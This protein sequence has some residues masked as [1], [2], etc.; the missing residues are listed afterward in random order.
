MP[1]SA[2]AF[3]PLVDVQARNMGEAQADVAIRGGIFET[4]GF[5][6]GAVALYDP[7]TGHYSAEI[8]AAP[9]MLSAPTVLTGADNAL[10]GW[11]ANAGTIAYEWRRVRAG[12]AASAG[13]G[14]HALRRAEAYQGWVAPAPLAAAAG[15]RRLAFDAALAAADSD[16]SRP[17]GESRFRRC[18]ARVQLAGDGGQTDLFYGRQSKFIGWPN[19]YTP[20]ADVFETDDLRTE[21]LVLNHREEL[22]GGDFVAAG[23]YWRRNADHYVFNRDGPAHNAGFGA[24]LP[25]RHTTWVRGAGVE[26][27]LA[28]GAV[29][30][31]FSASF[32]A[33]KLESDT[34]T[35]GRFNTRNHARVSLAPETSWALAGA[36]K[37]SVLAGAV[38]DD[39]NRDAPAVSPVARL[40]LANAAP[41][42]LADEVYV[43]CAA[44]SQVAT[45]TA[46]N[47]HPSAGLFRG[48][49]DL[50]RE[51][52]RA[53]ELGV[54]GARDNW[55]WTAAVFHRAERG[56]V[57]WIYRTSLPNARAA[58]AVD[59]DTTG[60]ELVARYAGRRLDLV[61]GYA[62][63]RKE[64][65]YGNTDADASFYA[66]N[67]PEHRLTA[68]VTVRA[69]RGWE[70]RLD[71]EARRQKPNA[72]RATGDDAVLSAFEVSYTPPRRPALRLKVAV[73]NL[74]DSDFQD[75]PSVPAA[76]RQWMAG[77]TLS[78]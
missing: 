14:A 48:A 29:A 7:Q 69:G 50:G 27:R 2:L 4:T 18:N 30:W 40:A 32:I 23:A 6:A 31:H 56:L 53:T 35:W 60:I 45:Y 55:A 12:G 64:A 75:V 77:A 39:T 52:A 43:S 17:F 19:L 57:D 8:P 21:L 5:R 34:L 58:S 42:A 59:I 3:E 41:G 15:G 47:S 37:L 54:K 62:G 24:P 65:D 16:G 33:D 28:T 25:S 67:F 26:G 63:L 73:D 74:W 46:L 9:A 11:N 13:A 76:R 1:V 38:F 72:L 51:K 49:P 68:A 70:I 66:L 78:W 44:S 22:G 71:N 10:G 36:R 61:L 20:Y